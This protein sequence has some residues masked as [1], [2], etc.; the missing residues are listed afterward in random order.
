MK[1]VLVI[2][3][4]LSCFSAASQKLAKDEVDEFT[5][6][7]IIE[8]EWV[9]FQTTFSSYSYIRL[10]KIDSI[11]YLNFKTG[12]RG[13][14]SIKEG[15]ELM[16]KL[17]NNDVVKLSN[18]EFTISSIGAGST[19]LNWSKTPGVSLYFKISMEDLDRLKQNVVVKTRL[20][21]TDGYVE[22]KVKEKRYKNF[23]KLISLI[24]Y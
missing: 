12:T 17:L 18:E 15:A 6:H 3:L 16:F 5:G 8:T 13:I 22:G 14:T 1:R 10:K 19:G 4:L 9:N 24:P 7:H 21:T 20:Y 23:S 2:L 11:I